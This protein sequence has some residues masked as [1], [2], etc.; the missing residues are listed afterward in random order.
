VIDWSNPW[1]IGIGTAIVSGLIVNAISNVL[2]SVKDR[3]RAKRNV[4]E[5]NSE[6]I[7]TLRT[8]LTEDS[9]LSIDILNA[10]VRSTAHK[11]G[12]DKVVMMS[13][14]LFSDTLIK[15][16]MDSS[17]LSQAQKSE[18]C[19]RI[20]HQ[21]SIDAK[22]KVSTSVEIKRLDEYYKDY[23]T[24]N[25]R[26]YSALISGLVASA[27]LITTSFA[28]MQESQREIFVLIFKAFWPI[29]LPLII[30]AVASVFIRRRLDRIK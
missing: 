5:A 14:E 9:P 21:L 26:R 15:E 25:R 28:T 8:S 29:M 2:W 4:S 22:E 13:T 3:S 24:D 12:L 17:F 11:Y 16:V 1:L 20:L 30:L 6:V 19:Q 27:A 10:L 7:S 18:Y 23:N